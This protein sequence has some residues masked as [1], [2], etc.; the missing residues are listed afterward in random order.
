MMRMFSEPWQDASLVGGDG[1][2]SIS[3]LVGLPPEL[4]WS[5]YTSAYQWRLL[6][7]LGM[8]VVVCTFCTRLIFTASEASKASEVALCA[9]ERALIFL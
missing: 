1:P 2:R 8:D 6:L 3:F 5:P 4:Q 7:L 9:A